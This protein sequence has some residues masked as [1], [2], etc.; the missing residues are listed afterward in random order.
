ME[1]KTYYLKDLVTIKN[2]KDHKNL[3]D[4][5]YPVLG[6]GGIMR[7]TDSFL[8]DKESILLPRKGSLSNIQFIEEPFWTVDTLFYTILK[9]EMYEPYYLYR[10][11]DFL[12]LSGYD[13][14]ASIPSMTVKSYGKI[15]VKLPSLDKQI[16]ISSTIK[17]YD[18]LIKNN[19]KRIKILEQMAEELYK[20]WFVRFRYPNHEKNNFNN[21]F[22]ENW[23]IKRINDLVEISAGG[24]APEEVSQIKDNKYSI[25]IY[26]N[27]SVKKGLYGYTNIASVKKECVTV[28]ARGSVGYICLRREPFLPIVRLLVLIP[29]SEMIDSIYLYYNLK[30]SYLEGNGTSQQ[31]ITKP[32]IGKKKILVPPKELI[33]KFTEYIINILDEVDNLELQNQNLEKQRDLLLPRLMSGKLEVK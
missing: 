18:L 31:Q 20:E 11:I 17:Q 5:Q 23:D 4:G 22:P 13:S 12:D 29:K 6:T 33:E 16:I 15:K 26:S 10:Y 3:N 32:M 19:N 9:T 28:S 21:G 24:D 2:G 8:Y 25:P 7:Y 1:F 30:N 14:G 27:S